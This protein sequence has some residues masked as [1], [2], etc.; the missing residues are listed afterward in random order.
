MANFLWSSRQRAAATATLAAHAHRSGK[1]PTP[2]G[3][4]AGVPKYMRGAAAAPS[5]QEGPHAARQQAASAAS[6]EAATAA[7]SSYGGDTASEAL[8]AWVD[9][10][11]DR[12]AREIGAHASSPEQIPDLIDAAL[13]NGR[14]ITSR[15]DPR[16]PPAFRS[17]PKTAS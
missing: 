12:V 16:I 1:P 14:L 8:C 15:T 17:T 13:D 2:A 5:I 7:P 10:Y 6:S 3:A 11:N 9:H 4:P